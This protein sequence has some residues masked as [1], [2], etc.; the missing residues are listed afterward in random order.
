MAEG[1]LHRTYRD[2]ARRLGWTVL[3]SW[4]PA[5]RAALRESGDED[6]DDIYDMIREVRVY[7]DGWRWFQEP[8]GRRV[9]HFLEIEVNHPVTP[10]KMRE[11]LQIARALD[12]CTSGLA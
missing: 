1:D 5:V 10:A 8:D 9:M 7:P 12:C 4:K 2:I 3:G 11:F 6:G